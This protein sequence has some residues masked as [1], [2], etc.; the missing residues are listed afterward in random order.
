MFFESALG[1]WLQISAQHQ[2]VGGWLVCANISPDAIAARKHTG[3]LGE[4][5]PGLLRVR[6]RLCVAQCGNAALQSQQAGCLLE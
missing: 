5:C 4:A 3:L 6:P 1:D 2:G